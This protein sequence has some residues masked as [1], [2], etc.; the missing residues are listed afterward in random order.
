EHFKVLFARPEQILYELTEEP[1]H[2]EPG[3]DLLINSSFETLD[4][5]LPVGWIAGDHPVIDDS[6]TESHDGRV[7]VKADGN[8]NILSQRVSLPS[9]GVYSLSFY[10]RGPEAG[11]SAQLWV[12]WLDAQQQPISSDAQSVELKHDWA[13]YEMLVSSPAQAVYA[14]VYVIGG[15]PGL[16]W[17]DDF[18]FARV[19]YR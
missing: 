18:S 17:F 2:C 19:L 8:A 7:A 13:R 9:L 12:D 1:S 15:G 11:P 3:P 5:R 6:G 14:N 16:V 4:Q 10:A